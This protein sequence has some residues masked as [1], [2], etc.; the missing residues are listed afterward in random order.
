MQFEIP[1]A[2]LVGQ[3]WQG[4]DGV[5]YQWSGMTWDVVEG[6]VLASRV[7]T[8]T[9]APTP[10]DLPFPADLWFNTQS[11]N[12]YVY[13]DDGNTAQ[14]VVTTPNRG[15]TVGPKGDKG[16]QGAPGPAGG[17]P[18]P[19][20]PAGSVG[21]AGPIGPQGIPGPM[22]PI[23]TVPGPAGPSGASIA[24]VSVTKPATPA[25]GQLWF[26]PDASAGGGTLYIYYNDGNT[27]QWVPVKG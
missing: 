15:G 12:F 20:G 1:N 25:D 18:G 2:P 8:C 14:W 4:P 7:P 5:R 3:L 16:D 17:P 13:Y 10:P 22:G 21:P 24:A 26:W 23:S 9:T 27:K 11:G 19:A 6:Q